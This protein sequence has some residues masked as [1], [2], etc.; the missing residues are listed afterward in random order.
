MIIRIYEPLFEIANN[1]ALDLAFG[2]PPNCL[3]IGI[4]ERLL[5]GIPSPKI[6][7]CE[8]PVAAPLAQPP[9]ED[10]DYSEAKTGRT[11]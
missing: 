2:D 6:W 1:A 5:M 8:F 4:G 3:L 11:R 7:T 9:R 10:F